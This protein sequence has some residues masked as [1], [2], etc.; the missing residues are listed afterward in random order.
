LGKASLVFSSSALGA[1]ASLWIRLL[2]QKSSHFMMSFCG[3]EVMT[4]KIRVSEENIDKGF[5]A[6]ERNNKFLAEKYEE[7]VRKYGGSVVA[8][9][10]GVVRSQGKTSAEVIK[11]LKRKK[12]DPLTVVIEYIPKEG[13]IILF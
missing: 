12:I 13:Q 11:E 3:G 10:D 4:K 2:R 7:L 6:I 8:V 9:S 5:E 1:E